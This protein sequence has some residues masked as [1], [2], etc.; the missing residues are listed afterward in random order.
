[1]PQKM[2]FFVKQS[3][4]RE[5]M[6]TRAQP[7]VPALDQHRVRLSVHANVARLPSFNIRMP[8]RPRLCYGSVDCDHASA[9]FCDQDRPISIAAAY[10]AT[11]LCML[12]AL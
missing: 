3:S 10:S 1:M 11:V 9:I 6:I 12:L 4:D 7:A 8:S 5:E 2:N